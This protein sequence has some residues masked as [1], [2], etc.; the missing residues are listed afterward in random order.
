M[1]G[2]THAC[3]TIVLCFQT[4]GGRLQQTRKVQR[5]AI[6]PDEANM[7]GSSYNTELRPHLDKALS[8]YYLARANCT[9]HDEQNTGYRKGP[10]TSNLRPDPTSSTSDGSEDLGTRMVHHGQPDW[11]KGRS[12]N[13]QAWK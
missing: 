12:D 1:L 6:E 13:G 9:Q 8:S 3:T 4:K 7:K 11:R 2:T 5:C 10:P